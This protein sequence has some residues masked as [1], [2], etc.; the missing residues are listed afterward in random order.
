MHSKQLSPL[1]CN[2]IVRSEKKNTWYALLE[3]MVAKVSHL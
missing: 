3:A 2:K 1:G